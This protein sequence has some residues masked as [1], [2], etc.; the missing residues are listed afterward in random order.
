MAKEISCQ[1]RS[2]SRNIPALENASKEKVLT[3]EVIKIYETLILQTKATKSTKSRHKT[4]RKPA[5]VNAKIIQ[6]AKAIR[7]GKHRDRG[8]RLPG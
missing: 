6:T 8:C 4:I 5:L 1:F 7:E 3:V 2:N